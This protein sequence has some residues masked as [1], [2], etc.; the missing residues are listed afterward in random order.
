MYLI[1]WWRIDS[2]KCWEIVDGEDAM[3]M[4]VCELVADGVPDDEITVAE[5][6]ETH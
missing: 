6:I 1:A 2:S 5:V 4:F 3:Q